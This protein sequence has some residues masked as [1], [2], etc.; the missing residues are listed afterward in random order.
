M[1]LLINDENRAPS[2][3]MSG[4]LLDDSILDRKERPASFG[5]RGSSISS[6]SNETIRSARAAKVFGKL[7]S[8]NENDNENSLSY[9]PSPHKKKK[10]LANITNVQ[11]NSPSRVLPFGTIQ[12]TTVKKPTKRDEDKKGVVDENDATSVKSETT[13][14]SKNQKKKSKKKKPTKQKNNSSQ[15]N[16]HENGRSGKNKL[17]PMKRKPVEMK[18]RLSSTHQV[19]ASRAQD[20]IRL[21]SESVNQ[22]LNA[23]RSAKMDHIQHVA[24]K[25]ARLRNEWKADKEEAKTFFEEVEKTKRE[26]LDIRNKLSSHYAQNKVDGDR[27][28]LQDKLNE[29]D[30][31]IMF[32][33]NVYVQHKKKLKENEDQ[34]RRMSVTIKGHHRNVRRTNIERMRLESIE[35]SHEYFEHKRGGERDAEEYKKRCEQERRESFAFRNAEGRRQRMEEAERQAAEQQK[36]HE[37]LEHK[38]EGERDAEEYKKR[39][40]QERR[41]SF[42]FRGREC[43]RHRAVMEELKALA[44]EKDHEYYVLK[45]AAQEDA[46][47]YLAQVAEERRQSLAFRNTEGRRQRELEAQWKF[48]DLQKV[49][50]IEELKSACQKDVE[51][52]E[53]KCAERDRMSLC[54]RGKEVVRQRLETEMEEQREYELD[55]DRRELETLARFDVEDYVED[56]KKRRRKSLAV[57][58]KEHRRH[59]QWEKEQAESEREEKSR[60]S[61]N[62]ALDR[63]YVELA[64][65]KERARIAL[66]A[67]RHAQSSFSS[68]NPFGSL[69]D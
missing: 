23:S 8:E 48:E 42:A 51:E 4:S 25:V 36:E 7:V 61:K 12:F 41:E 3:T 46:K 40:E 66:N 62:A 39:C 27:V 5:S 16:T 13:G 45:W 52:Y 58:A 38:W 24:A 15:S 17:P 37:R 64:K 14:T 69:L 63:K 26:M 30:K 68:S 53:N 43:V 28:K 49:H 44:Q 34:R 56:C 9:S 50:E 18:H 20:A 21:A 57:R 29:L 59:L 10:Q 1:V 35:E 33:S 67:L 54:Y 22:S 11:T 55:Q 31:E 6:N 65:Q 60:R 2:N 47:S 19:Q 32:K